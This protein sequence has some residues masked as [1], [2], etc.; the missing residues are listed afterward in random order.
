MIKTHNNNNIK[1]IKMIK[2]NKI[3]NN[4]KTQFLLIMVNN[5]NLNKLYTMLN[6]IHKK[7][8]IPNFQPNI[9]SNF[10]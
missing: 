6:Q 1:I 2:N 9:I 3:N 10:K 5:S 4:L 7:I 8:P